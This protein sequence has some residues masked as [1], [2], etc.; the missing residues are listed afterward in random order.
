MDADEILQEYLDVISDAVMAQD[1]EAYQGKIMLP[2]Q[3]ITHTAN[4]NVATPEELRAGFEAFCQTLQMQ[5][6]THY[7]RLVETAK[8]LDQ[9]L[10]TGRYV[11]HLMAGAH[12]ILPPYTSQMTLRRHGGVWRA[13]SITNSLANSRWPF[14]GI[15]VAETD[16]TAEISPN[17][18]PIE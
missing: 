1:W 18:G 8:R 15:Q 6:V 5:K 2:L 12:R 13:V 16:P 11:S 17:E 4:I 9:D 10:I 7:V 14:V 3:L